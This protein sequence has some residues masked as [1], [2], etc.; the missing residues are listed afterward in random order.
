MAGGGDGQVVGMGITRQS[1]KL[2]LTNANE[3]R[4]SKNH[5]TKVENW[6]AK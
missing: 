2:E 6:C 3:I 5:C 4:T 1:S